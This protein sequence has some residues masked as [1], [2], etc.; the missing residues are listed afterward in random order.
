MKKTNHADREPA[1]AVQIKEL[2]DAIE[3]CIQRFSNETTGT[4]VK[5]LIAEFEELMLL[6]TK[7]LTQMVIADQQVKHICKRYYHLSERDGKKLIIKNDENK[8]R[9]STHIGCRIRNADRNS[10]IALGITVITF[11][12]IILASLDE[13]ISFVDY[14]LSYQH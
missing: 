8:N 5:V 12:L 13:I 4:G 2:D 7:L 6:K 1:M 11:I 14:V 9:Q 10:N 3:E